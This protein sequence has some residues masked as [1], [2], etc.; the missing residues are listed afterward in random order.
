MNNVDLLLINPPFHTRNGG[1]SF[2]PLG[3]G[4]I[5]SSVIAHGYSWGLIDCTRIIHSF[6]PEDLSKLKEELCAEIKKYSPTV[7]GIGPC[8]TTQL[9]A[10]KII[11]ECCKK[12]FPSVP[13]IVGGPLASISGQEWLFFE[14]LGINYIVKGDAELAIPDAIRAVKQTGTPTNSSMISK[15]GY[16]YIN[17]IQDLDTLQFP[18]RRI[19][20]QDIY[21]IRRLASSC[22]NQ[23]AMITSRGCPYACNFCVSGN[24]PQKFRKRSTQNIV[25]EM[26]HLFINY[27]VS[28]IIFYDDCFFSNIHSITDDIRTFCESLL[29]KGLNMTWQMEMRPDMLLSLDKDSIRAL[30]S[31]GCRQINIGIEKVSETGLKFLGKQA[32]LSGLREKILQIKKLSTISLSAT[33]ILGGGTETRYDVLELVD[34]SICLGLDFA[35]YN[36]LFVYP[37]TPLYSYAFKNDRLWVELIYDD[38]LPWGEIVFE[39]ENIKRVDLLDLVDYAYR[40]F[41]KNTRYSGQQMI[42]DRF[43]IKNG[44]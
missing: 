37:G 14:E 21:S 28:D 36:P 5:I 40:E 30:D 6:F 38:P 35:H 43:N 23:A 12:A 13:M 32:A 9:R 39:N 7:I 17:E 18:Y 4:Y 16:T 24:S 42:T 26:E 20:D 8:I 25:D 22:R 44:R 33:F 10:L 34:K 19:S 11:T 41:Y 29:S 1:G 27:D 31:C 15:P 2:L 3:L